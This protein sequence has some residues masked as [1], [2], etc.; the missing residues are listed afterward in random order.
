MTVLDIFSLALCFTG[1]TVLLIRREEARQRRKEE[2]F[3]ALF[4]VLV[5]LWQLMG[6]SKTKETKKP[7]YKKYKGH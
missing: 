5:L 1:I 6:S 2:N 3:T 4:A 7:K